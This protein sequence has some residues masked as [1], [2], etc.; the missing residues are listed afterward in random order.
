MEKLQKENKSLKSELSKLNLALKDDFLGKEEERYL[1]LEKR[2][3]ELEQRVLIQAN[4]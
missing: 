4:T 2:N 3:S 1:L